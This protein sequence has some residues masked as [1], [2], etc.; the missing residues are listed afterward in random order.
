MEARSN[1][2]RRPSHPHVRRKTVRPRGTVRLRPFGCHPV[3]SMRSCERCLR[4]G[5]HRHTREP[6]RRLH[7]KERAPD[8]DCV[9]RRECWI[10]RRVFLTGGAERNTRIRRAGGEERRRKAEFGGGCLLGREVDGGVASRRQ[11]D[12]ESDQPVVNKWSGSQVGL[13]LEEANA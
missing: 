8:V 4:V 5:R 6:P 9:G 13:R 11:E 3:R 2:E 1:D 7:I 12:E 10:C